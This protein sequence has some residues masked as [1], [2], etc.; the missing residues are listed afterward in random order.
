V[1]IGLAVV[2]P[3]V[4][5]GVAIAIQRRAFARR[6]WTLVVG[7]QAVVLVSALAATWSGERE[8]EQ[9][10]A[11]LGEALVEHHEEAGE[12]LAWAAGVVLGVAAV[13]LFLADRTAKWMRLVTVIAT[14]VVLAIAFQAGH[15][16]GVL[17]FTHGANVMRTTGEPRVKG[18]P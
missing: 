7:L 11:T 5:F 2:M 15:S 3:L 1:P 17:V 16:G 4:A 8:A 18:G 13:A 12:A 14:L 9:V 10:E 6:V